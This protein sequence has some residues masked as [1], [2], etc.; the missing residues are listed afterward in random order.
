MKTKNY[1]LVT[2]LLA[3]SFVV[4]ATTFYVRNIGDNINDGLSESTAV[5]TLAK[6]IDLAVTDGDVINVSGTVDFYST[7]ITQKEINKSITIQGDDKTT[8]VVVGTASNG[9]CPIY[10]GKIF[11]R[12]VTIENLTFKDFYSFNGTTNS[13][14]GVIKFER[15][16]LTISNV[17]FENNTAYQG[18]A[19]YLRNSHPTA[20]NNNV[21]LVQDCYF[22][23]NKAL[24]TS[25]LYPSGGAVFCEVYTSALETNSFK[26]TIDRCTFDANI[27]EYSGAALMLT[28]GA[29]VST[30][31]GVLVQNSTIVN[32]IV[33]YKDANPDRAA[34]YIQKQG[35][36][37]YNNEIK[38]VNNTIAYNSVERSG[39]LCAG[40]YNRN[41]TNLKII[42]NIFFGNTTTNATLSYE[43]HPDGTVVGSRNNIVDIVYNPGNSDNSLNT[44]TTYSGNTENVTAVQLKLA[45]SLADNDGETK[46]L[47]LD[48]GSVA[49]NAGYSTID[50]VEDQRG[51]LRVDVPDVGAY[52]YGGTLPPR[53]FYVRSTGDDYKDGLSEETALETVSEAIERATVDGDV[54]DISGT[55]NFYKATVASKAITKR[56]TFKGDNKNTTIVVGVTTNNISPIV[57]GYSSFT[58]VKFEDMTFK[59]FNR[60]NAGY[61]GVIDFMRGN[62]ICKNVI[63]ENNTAL[64]GGAISVRNSYSQESNSNS[65]FIQDCHF[66]GNSTLKSATAVTPRGGG[67][68]CSS[69]NSTLVTNE[70]NFTIDRCTFE[71][72]ISEYSGSA[73]NIYMGTSL[74][75]NKVL[76]QNSTFLNNVNKAG[77]ANANQYPDQ[78]SVYVHYSAVSGGT[79]NSEVKLIN[80][81]IAYN[82]VQ[83]TGYRCAGLYN[84]AYPGL[85]IYNNL[86][87]DNNSSDKKLSFVTTVDM[88]VSRNNIVDVVTGVTDNSLN[89]ATVFSNNTENVT[90]ENLKLATTLADNGGATKTLSLDSG[91]IAIDA[92]YLPIA[93]VKD[94][95]GF[96]HINVPDAGAYEYGGTLPANTYYVRSTGRDDIN[97]G[98]SE[99]TAVQTIA[100]AIDLA[101][102]DGDV[103]NVSGV[104]NFCQDTVVQKEINHNVTIH[105]DDKHTAVVVGGASNGITPLYLGKTSACAV[106][107]KNLTFKDFYSFNGTTNSYGGVI[108]FERGNLT[109]SNV[110]FENNTAYQ[111]GALY[112]RNSH[113]TVANDNVVL[114]QDCYFKNNKALK[115]S[116][117]YPYGGAVFCEIYTSTSA[118]NSFKV[119]I[120]R[121]T[122]D[123]NT[124]EYGGAALM[125]VGGASVSTTGGVLV[126]N[127]T[128]VN[129]EVKYKDANPDRGAVYIQK[130]G[131][132][133]YNNE[134]KF[135]NNTIAYNNVERSGYMCAG[136]YNR[137]YPNFKIFNNIFLG[138]KTNDVTLSYETHPDGTVVESRNNIVDKVYNVGNQNN[139]LNQATTYSDNLQDATVVDLKL[140][141]NLAYNGGATPTLNIASGSVAQDA[142]Y[143]SAA[144]EVDQRG[145]MRVDT[146]DVGAFEYYPKIIGDIRSDHPRLFFN[147][148]SWNSVKNRA[149]S[150]SMENEYD[151]VVDLAYHDSPYK[152]D[153]DSTEI[154]WPATRPGYTIVAGDWGYNVM[155]AAFV[156]RI[157]PSTELLTR[158]KEMLF[159]SLDYYHACYDAD[160]AVSW[161]VYSR[162]GWLAAMDW[163]WYDLTA[164]ERQELGSGFF[165]HVDDIFDTT[166]T[167]IGRNSDGIH[168][169][170]DAGYYGEGNVA[171]YA[172][173]TFYNED[174]DNQK[175]TNY[176]ERGITE[177]E[178]IFNL[179][180]SF[181]GKNGGLVSPTLAYSIVDYPLA[182]WNFFHCWQSATGKNAA[183]TI[184]DYVTLFPNYIFWNLVPESTNNI[185][186]DFGIGDVDHMTNEVKGSE[187][188]VFTNLSHVM[189]FYGQT[190]PEVAGLAAYLRKQFGGGYFREGEYNREPNYPKWFSNL[191]VYPFLLTSVDETEEGTLPP[192]PT[193]MHFDTHGQVM[194]RSGD[195]PNDT[196]ALFTCGGIVKQ[197]RHYDDNHFVI[198]RKGYQTL[199]S[200]TRHGNAANLQNYYAQTVAHNSVLINMP[201]ESAPAHWNGTVYSIDGGQYS[202]ANGSIKAFETSEDYTYVAGDATASYRS[203]KCKEAVRQF[204]FIP[205]YHF[206]V[207]DRVESTNSGYPKRWL[208]HH[209]DEPV[210]TG[211]T[212]SA[213]HENGKLFCKTLLPEDATFTKI[214]GPGQYFWADG[215]NWPIDAP[216]E[217]VAVERNLQASTLTYPT[218]TMG[219]WRMEV[220][221]GTARAKDAFL[222][223]IQVCDA[224]VMNMDDVTLENDGSVTIQEGTREIN[225][226]F[227]ESGEIGG[228]INIKEGTT[229]I[230]DKVLASEVLSSSPP[231]YYVKL[232]GD[233]PND[234]TTP[235]IKSFFG[236]S[237]DGLTSKI[238]AMLRIYSIDGRVVKSELVKDGQVTNL[239]PGVYVIHVITEDLNI[240]QKII[241]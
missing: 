191:P 21:V 60:G 121:C 67:V 237:R 175:A 5:Q 89:R 85:K 213:G 216:R 214:G 7:T 195:G 194:M 137:N 182:E 176:L 151:L 32:S 41:Y 73:L 29:S 72:N 225:V 146:S 43:T 69:G 241:L 115:A 101:V 109:I 90:S 186:R 189:H 47:S 135:V 122:F 17:I 22:K 59:N 221:P 28:G 178:V 167:I 140:S 114:I 38:F 25:S 211:N 224:T 207:Y 212:W 10:I 240:I 35:S 223:V 45:A 9:I 149:L 165:R 77:G 172:G 161:Y 220:S 74:S 169:E 42:N 118:T 1:M 83:K 139:S 112:F 61:G 104:V 86:F 58:T 159:A 173:L 234:Y 203:T 11:F 228:H 144:P 44:A 68:F 181:A 231:V 62:L 87:F 97:D 210:L 157:T 206:V 147:A 106:E 79:Y 187:G 199:D 3:I 46:T 150:A 171:L 232:N 120:D 162:I 49:N 131:S 180:K 209:A 36:G 33:K 222:H 217:P 200:G 229:T 48:S 14:G 127:S 160:R 19:L 218:P 95:R 128:I 155:A 94:Q 82:S 30:T 215:K 31:G 145:F 119:T 129:N 75:E 166:R 12:T 136:L 179:R 4:Q 80:N 236:I 153:W 27:S 34:I 40:L 20:A 124:S 188:K 177:Y 184:G 8:A 108:K 205:P 92:G 71:S 239:I 2:F 91:S 63:F 93:P 57:I 13:Y 51:Y 130:Q 15:G 78:G 201:G 53:T 23:S 197:H 99:S 204:V 107:I 238:D 18:G 52:E 235:D 143:V 16:N 226:K 70:F 158:I 125:L 37:T 138:N 123:A 116:S 192:Q 202:I 148:E 98:L 196:Y 126:Q 168:G 230:V 81:T 24:K 219:R 133:T 190:H 141:D 65:V 154:D 208:L 183:N 185:P 142:G 132:G 152:S 198:F 164:E 105:G 64:F 54:I 6:A 103:I 227:N 96:L 170:T 110:I 233:E 111:G 50:L 84:A 39:Y 100:R 113:P 55:V 88:L 76:V 174:I 56:I 163:V 26:V 66:K 193:A 117:L 134:I 102:T 156:Y